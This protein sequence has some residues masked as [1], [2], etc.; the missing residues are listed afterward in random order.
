MSLADEL[1]KLQELKLAGVLTDDEFTQAKQK[2]LADDP[3]EDTPAPAPPTTTIKLSLKDGIDEIVDE[4]ST[5]GQAANRYVDYNY[6]SLIIG[7]IIFIIAILV[8]V[9]LANGMEKSFHKERLR[10]E[11]R[12]PFFN[13]QQLYHIDKNGNISI[14]K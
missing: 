1:N 7:A 9:S 2:L 8:F 14:D 6:T 3:D 13:N 5:L 11:E 10:M 12:S 4:K